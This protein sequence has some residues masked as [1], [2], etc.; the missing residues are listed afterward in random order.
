MRKLA[1]HV[2]LLLILFLTISFSLCAC[3]VNKSKL[4]ESESNA[5]LEKIQDE[6]TGLVEE[7]MKKKLTE[8]EAMALLQDSLDIDNLHFTVVGSGEY[9][10]E[11]AF[12]I[13]AFYDEEDHITTEG[14]YII[15]KSS[16][17]I[18][19]QNMFGEGYIRIK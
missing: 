12:C 17:E 5:T 8:N 7:S 14:F 18:Y 3:D 10:D 15:F 2:L 9:M 6:T 13:R 1:L 19:K 4:I 16:G 11:E